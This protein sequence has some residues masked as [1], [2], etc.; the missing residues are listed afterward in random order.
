MRRRHLPILAA[1]AA[2]SASNA[3]RTAW[4]QPAWPSRPI[5]IIVTFPPGGSSDIVARVLAEALSARLP[6]RVLVENKPGAGG[7]LGAA[8]VA[9]QPADGLTLMLS[10]TAPI[11]TSPPIYASIP[12]D[13]VTSFTHIAY[14]G[15]TPLVV[16]VNPRLVPATDLAGLVAWIKAQRVPPGYGSS[17][18]GSVAHIFGEA[19]TKRTGAELTHVPYRGSAPMQADLLG[20]AIPLSFDTLP[21]NVE[22]IRAGRLRAIAITAPARQEMAPEVPTTAEGGYPGLVAE[23]WLGLA[24]PAGLP[25]AIAARLH[26]ETL[27]ALETPLMTARILE[28]GIAVRPMSQA[29]F[30]SFVAEE[31]RVVGGAVRALGLTAQ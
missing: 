4:A 13:P 7:T 19:F 2:C 5:R 22:N 11:V 27:A 20:G 21:Q 14:L 25:A 26:T 30:T 23:N 18:A 17:G 10:N 16:V 3:P 28:H 9:S 31:V 6:Q 15:A 29:D 12:Y 1:L 24:A 8:Y